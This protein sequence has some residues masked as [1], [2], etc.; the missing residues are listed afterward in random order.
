[1]DIKAL[2]PLAIQATMFLVIMAFAMRCHWSDLVATLRQPGL[3]LRAFIAVNLVVPLV[4][5]VIFLIFPLDRVVAV[6]MLLMAVSPLAPLVPGN[7]LK[8]GGDRAS[9]IGVYTILILLAILVVPLTVLI[10]NDLVGGQAVAT[11]PLVGRV[12]L[13]SALLPIAAGLTLATWLPAF[14]ERAAP[15]IGKAAFA[16]LGVVLVFIL[17][18]QRGNLV[19]LIGDGTLAV[20]TAVTLAGLA[21]GHLLGGPDRGGRGA[22]AIAA[23]TRHPG[24]AIAIA[25]A[26]QADPRSGLAIMLFLLNG[27]V[28]S[29][30]YQAWL[31]RRPAAPATAEEPT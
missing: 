3:L 30:L 6:A 14:S 12:V 9:V 26:N 19:E 10:I 29:A 23:A 11:L 15:F 22:L 7:A 18:A 8:A 1:M 4:A 24:I 28:V 25:N 13:I 5:L 17:W 16:V 27:V 31:K 21:A 2:I 20:F